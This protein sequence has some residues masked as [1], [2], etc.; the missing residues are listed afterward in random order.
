[1]QWA[2]AAC[3]PAAA[4]LAVARQCLL[5]PPGTGWP[6]TSPNSYLC[7]DT[8]AALRAVA[9][10]PEPRRGRT[11]ARHHPAPARSGRTLSPGTTSTSA[12]T[13]RWPRRRGALRT[14]C[15]RRSNALSSS[16]AT[17]LSARGS[18][19]W[20]CASWCTSSST[21]TSRLHVGREADRG[22]NLV[23][24]LVGGPRDQPARGVGWGAPAAARR[25]V[26]RDGPGAHYLPPTGCALAAGQPHGLGPGEPGA[27]AGRSTRSASGRATR[28]LPPAPTWP[29]SGR[30]GRPAPSCRRA[31]AWPGVSMPCLGPPV[32]VPAR[33]PR[34]G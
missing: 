26:R 12:I 9:R 29:G 27:A 15:W 13:A 3:C 1:M 30:Y 28:P 19:A 32:A 31:S 18:E 5:V 11:V 24:V 7:P 14:T 2:A 4:G 17:V 21:C 16:W 25:P 34:P 20:R 22:G 6:G 10:R 23:P 8:R 33:L